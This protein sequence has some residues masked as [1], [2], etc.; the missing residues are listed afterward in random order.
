MA[1][2]AFS[3]AIPIPLASWSHIAQLSQ[4]LSAKGG[5][6]A[7]LDSD[8][9]ETYKQLIHDPPDQ[10]NAI[11]APRIQRR[12]GGSVSRPYLNSM[13]YRICVTLQ[14]ALAHHRLFNEPM[15]WR[16]PGQV[17]GLFCRDRPGKAWWV[18]GGGACSGF[19]PVC[20]RCSDPPIKPGKSIA[21]NSAVFLL[22]LG[23]FPSSKSRSHLA[24]SLPDAKRRK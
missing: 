5:D 11:A 24:L 13:R 17:L 10:K 23:L 9:E 22:F 20:A 1:K 14:R 7:L 3:V 21:C 16:P 12:G 18:G 8:H 19:S 6:W 4:L 2:L 15:F